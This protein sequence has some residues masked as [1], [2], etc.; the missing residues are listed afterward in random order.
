MACAYR[1]RRG[2]TLV[3]LTG[4]IVGVGVLLVI[5]AVIL[6]AFNRGGGMGRAQLLRESV[7]LSHMFSAYAVYADDHNGTFPLPSMIRRQPV[8]V[9]GTSLWVDGRGEPDV[10][11]NTTARLHSAMVMDDYYTADLLIS[12]AE[13]SKRVV[14]KVDYNY[15][16]YAPV[17][18][19]FWD[20]TLACD[21]ATESHVSF[22]NLVLRDP[23]LTKAWC[24][25][26]GS[27]HALLSTR[28]P[29]DGDVDTSSITNEFHRPHDEW[30]G[31]IVYSDGRTEVDGRYEKMRQLFAPSDAQLGITTAMSE[32]GATLSWD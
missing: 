11:Q 21:L 30:V 19:R 15:E 28:G 31:N 22:A 16:C 14:E 20:D 1:T 12:H 29:R 9:E 23:A 27:D 24:K 3:Q 5:A 6:P 17:E 26:R 25:T 10:T 32:D 18:G 4:V 2:F 8:M 7:Q 13:V